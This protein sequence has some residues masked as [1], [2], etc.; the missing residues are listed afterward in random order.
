LQRL[1]AP[2]SALQR[3]AAPCSALQRLSA[4]FSALQRLSAPCLEN[5]FKN[6]L[7]EEMCEN[8]K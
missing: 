5:G 1:A 7:M 6:G 8:L 4:P 2:Y 3:L